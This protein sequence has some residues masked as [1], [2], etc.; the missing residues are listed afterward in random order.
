MNA[1]IEAGNKQFRVSK[2]DTIRIP[3]ETLAIKKKMVFRPVMAYEGEELIIDPG[4]L[5]KIKVHATVTGEDSR[6]LYSLKKKAKTGYKRGR[7]HRER[8]AVITI[9]EIEDKREQQK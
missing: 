2:G 5:K 8:I 6:K 1:M 4:A 3:S 9:E 7:G